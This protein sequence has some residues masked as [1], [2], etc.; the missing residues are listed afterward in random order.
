MVDLKEIES[1]VG[2]SGA[3]LKTQIPAALVVVLDEVRKELKGIRDMLSEIKEGGI[4]QRKTVVTIRPGDAPD[5]PEN[6]D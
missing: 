6:K 1:L 5:P 2:Y 4:E 3:S